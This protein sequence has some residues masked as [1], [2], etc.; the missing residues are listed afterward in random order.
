MMREK[1]TKKTQPS[2]ILTFWKRILK[3]FSLWKSK[4]PNLRILSSLL[5][6]KGENS[7]LGFSTDFTFLS[8]GC[9][10]KEPF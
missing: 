7:R 9:H 8:V 10:L 1:K 4:Y 2:Q 3:I 5:I 6:K